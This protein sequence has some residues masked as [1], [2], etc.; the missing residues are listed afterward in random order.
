MKLLAIAEKSA[1]SAAVVKGTLKIFPKG[2][3][4]PIE[5][6]DEFFWIVV[7]MRSPFNGALTSDL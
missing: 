1:E 2:G 4:D 6:T 3:G 7:T 5:V